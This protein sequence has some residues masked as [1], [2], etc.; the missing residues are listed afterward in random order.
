MVGAISCGDINSLDIMKLLD[1]PYKN[2]K[3][4]HI[5]GVSLTNCWRLEWHKQHV[6]LTVNED[7]QLM[8]G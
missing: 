4:W 5:K 7:L 8:S 6:L 1:D 2:N 3:I